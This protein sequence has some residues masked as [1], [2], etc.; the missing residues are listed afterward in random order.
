MTLLHHLVEEAEKK[1]KDALLF[2]DDLLDLLQK[3]ARFSL[4]QTVTEFN[5]LR[6]HV[7]E[8]KSKVGKAE[9]EEVKGQFAEFMEVKLIT[10]CKTVL[11][12]YDQLKLVC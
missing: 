11:V 7:E 2:V 1:N 9:D 6:K 5:Q 10:I 12:S 3:A 8:I 4:T